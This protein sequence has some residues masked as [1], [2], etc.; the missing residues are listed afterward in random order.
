MFKTN[1][2]T[3]RLLARAGAA[4]VYPDGV[5]VREDKYIGPKDLRTKVEVWHIY[6]CEIS[7]S[8]VNYQGHSW[9]DHKWDTTRDPQ[10]K[11]LTY[12]DPKLLIGGLTQVRVSYYNKSEAAEKKGIAGTTVTLHNPAGQEI[13]VDIYPWASSQVRVTPDPVNDTWGSGNSIGSAIAFAEREE[14]DGNHVKWH[15]EKPEPEGESVEELVDWLRGSRPEDLAENERRELRDGED[16]LPM[17]E[18][19]PKD[20]EDPEVAYEEYI[21]RV[22]K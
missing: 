20:Y 7:F 9:L 19:D 21:R 4:Y 1:A 17:E 10:P 5:V 13:D 8:G 3:N 22:E 11:G 6:P 2:A 15:G 12:H 16:V 14:K 18:V